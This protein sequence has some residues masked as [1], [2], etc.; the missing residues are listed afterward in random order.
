MS[1]QGAFVTLF[2]GPLDGARIDVTGWTRSQRAD[3]MAHISE[4][5]RRPGGPAVY[6]P[7]EGD[8]LADVWEWQGDLP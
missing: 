8:P 1:E 7:P 4:H 5:G 3:G 6:G 2:G